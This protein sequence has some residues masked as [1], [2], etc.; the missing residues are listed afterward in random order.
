MI[1]YK[2]VPLKKVGL[3]LLLVL[4][5]LSTG[6]I[7]LIGMISIWMGLNHSE[8]QGFWMPILTGSLAIMIILWLF[9]R[10]VKFSLDRMK[11]KDTF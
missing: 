3:W 1:D 6:Y 11:E 5:G 7:V 8:E 4:C 9:L 10:L 2:P